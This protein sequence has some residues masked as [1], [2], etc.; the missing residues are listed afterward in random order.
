M[1]TSPPLVGSIDG[2]T[3]MCV[4]ARIGTCLSLCPHSPLCASSSFARALSNTVIQ[5][6]RIQAV[7]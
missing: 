5:L 1:R 3:H 2:T 6:T 4:C 7:A